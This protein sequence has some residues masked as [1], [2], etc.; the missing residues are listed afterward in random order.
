[1]TGRAER[2]KV[3]AELLVP[4]AGFARGPGREPADW[5]AHSP[6]VEVTFPGAHLS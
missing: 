1:M 4:L 2:E 3:L 5:V 6:L